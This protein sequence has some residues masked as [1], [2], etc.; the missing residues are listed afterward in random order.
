MCCSTERLATGNTPPMSHFLCDLVHHKMFVLVVYEW[1]SEWVSECMYIASTSIEISKQI[2]GHTFCH[3]DIIYCLCRFLFC[4]HNSRI[5][6]YIT[7]TLRHARFNACVRI[8]DTM[9]YARSVA[10]SIRLF[11]PV[12]LCEKKSWNILWYKKR[13]KKK[14]DSNKEWIWRSSKIISNYYIFVC[15]CFSIERDKH[16]GFLSCH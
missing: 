1:L 5:H 11:L 13:K 15:V 16:Y 3:F 6:A 2:I 12:I 14:G 9:C 8:R 7:H 10:V 4:I